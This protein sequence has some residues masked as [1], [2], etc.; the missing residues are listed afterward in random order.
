M[1][2]NGSQPSSGQIG[3]MAPEFVLKDQNG[4][5]FRLSTFIGKRILL[6]FLSLAWTAESAEQV[7]VLEANNEIFESLNTVAVAISV[8]SVPS[9][10][11]WAANLGIAKLRLLCDFWPHGLVADEYEVL[12][13]MVGYSER[14]NI[15]VD[16]NGRIAFV[17]KYGASDAPDIMEIIKM[18]KPS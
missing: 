6:S 1:V 15:I 3:Q 10:K 2:R 12:R 8:D 18:L 7:K 5:E 11:A 13:Q 4:A 14:A 17:R 16:E 9:K